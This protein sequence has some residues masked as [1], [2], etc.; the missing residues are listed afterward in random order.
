MVIENVR[1]VS[2]HIA[3]LV[4]IK[5]PEIR[6]TSTREEINVKTGEGNTVTNYL[7]KAAVKASMHL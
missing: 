6:T 5:G 4:D 1:A 7:A 3:I 2:H